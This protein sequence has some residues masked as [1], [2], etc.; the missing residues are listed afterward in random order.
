MAAHKVTLIL[1]HRIGPLQGVDVSGST[2]IYL[3]NKKVKC[4]EAA[5]Y[6]SQ[7]NPLRE[8]DHLRRPDS[9]HY[10]TII[11]EVGRSQSCES[12]AFNAACVLLGTGCC[13][14]VVVTIKIFAAAHKLEKVAIDVWE[15][16]LARL[17]VAETKK[18][19][20]TSGNHTTIP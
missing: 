16:K 6:P 11:L 18:R 5:I 19:S 17:R 8:G 20:C 7:T 3:F 13:V 2:D 1:L 10:P 15:A 9:K 4:S 12:L 14:R